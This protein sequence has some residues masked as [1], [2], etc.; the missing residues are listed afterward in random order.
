V[1]R[2]MDETGDETDWEIV[3]DNAGDAIAFYREAFGAAELWRECLLDGW[4]LAAEL[5]LGPYRL[6]LTD[7]LGS[8][9]D[10]HTSAVSTLTF[11]C[12]EPDAAFARA[13]AAGGLADPGDDPVGPGGI[14]R[15]SSGHRWAI[16]G[17]D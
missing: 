5:A 6:R 1:G 4:V 16:I 8:P 3:V 17:L 10:N 2:D 14:V 13:I 12:P 9:A 15:D 11:E 7:A